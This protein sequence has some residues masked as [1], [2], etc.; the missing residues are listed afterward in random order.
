MSRLIYLGVLVAC[1][2][3][4]LPLEVFFAAGVYR[5][6]RRAALAILPVAVAFVVWDVL[7]TAA[8]WWW[9]NPSYVIG[10]RLGGLPVEELMFFLIIPLCAILTLEA[11]RHLR[12][13]WDPNSEPSKEPKT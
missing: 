4:T 1:L 13:A 5:R 9:F 7:A 3:G 2:V 11:V 12:P 8:G 10:V 6:W